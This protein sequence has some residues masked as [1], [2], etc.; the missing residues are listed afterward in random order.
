M[1]YKAVILAASLAFALVACPPPPPPAADFTISNVN[2]GSLTF[3]RPATGTSAPQ[4]LTVTIAPTNGFAD[5]VALSL[6]APAGVTGV[7]GSGTIAAGASSGTLAVTVSNTTA[8][9]TNTYTVQAVSGSITRTSNV[10]ITVNAPGGVASI[11]VSGPAGF[12]GPLKLNTPTQFTAVAKDASNNTLS[13]VSFTWS[14]SDANTVSVDNTGLATAKKLSNSAVTLTATA[15]GVNG[16]ISLTRTF[17]LEVSAGTYNIKD[18]SNNTSLGLGL[19]MRIRDTNGAVVN[20]NVAGQNFTI[21]G[22]TGWNGNAAATAVGTS[23]FLWG[24][25]NAF[26]FLR[27]PP[28][29]NATSPAAVV[30][31]YTVNATISSVSYTGKAQITSVASLLPAPSIT[32][33]TVTGSGGTR[34]V[35]A[36]WGAVTGA[37]SYRVQVLKNGSVV[38]SNNQ[39]ATSRTVSGIA[40]T[41]G[42]T[43]LVRVIAYPVDVTATDVTLPAQFNISSSDKTAS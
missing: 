1:K 32:T 25:G 40:F 39:T 30:G 37:A 19:L 5:A 24:A 8:T 18:A 28:A 3:N 29:T 15:S 14:S 9:G 38:D 12:T 26:A 31:E 34:T 16:T 22:P 42:D 27:T 36:T 43:F 10:S 20:G 33:A 17:G 21:T 23:D 11:T 4:N 2:P 6:V 35:S 41:S 13:G 7:S